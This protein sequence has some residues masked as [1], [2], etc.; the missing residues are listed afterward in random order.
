MN[1]SITPPKNGLKYVIRVRMEEDLQ[2]DAVYDER[3]ESF[4]LCTLSYAPAPRIPLA[5]VQFW[6]A[7]W[8]VRDLIFANREMLEQKDNVGD[9]TYLG[10]IT[11][12]RI[13]DVMDL[14]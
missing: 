11:G 4:T 14:I 7:Q 1:E 12:L 13:V 9:A 10:K 8:A 6:I 5:D 2:F 3:T